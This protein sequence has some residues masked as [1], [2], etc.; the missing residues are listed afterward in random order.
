MLE[1]FLKRFLKS[2][3]ANNTDVFIYGDHLLMAGVQRHAKL[4]EP[5]YLT[6]LI[7]FRPR[8]LI[9]KQSSIYDFAPTLLDS[10]GVDFEPPF[11]FGASLF[12]DRV[13]IVP[14]PAHLQFIYDFF[15]ESMQWNQTARCVIAD[16]RFCRVT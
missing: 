8:Q 11:P 10:I 1:H 7:P 3:L 9:T 6:A 2:R 5:R 16:N 12:S 14:D 15:S 13:G 4:L